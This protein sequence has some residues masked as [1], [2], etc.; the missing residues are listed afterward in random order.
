MESAS[1]SFLCG[2]ASTEINM[3]ADAYDASATWSHTHLAQLYILR[4][5]EATWHSIVCDSCELGT[6]CERLRAKH[7]A[8][9]A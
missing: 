7:H 5:S 6:E 8:E 1:N 9:F 3:A 2:R 4:C